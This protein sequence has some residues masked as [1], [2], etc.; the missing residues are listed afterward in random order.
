MRRRSPSVTLRLTVLFALVST[1]GLLSLGFFVGK[2]VSRHFVELDDAVLINKT[3]LV[4][5]FISRVQSADDLE[6]L[7]QQLGDALVE[8]RELAASVVDSSG[9]VVFHTPNAAF[10]A[11]LLHPGE[12]VFDPQAWQ[13]KGIPWRGISSLKPTGNPKIGSLLVA[14]AVDI[15]HHQRFLTS[16]RTSLWLFVAVTAGIS[17]LLGWAAVRR[18]MAPLAKMREDTAIVTA[19]RLDNR[20]DL[21]D[22]PSEFVDLAESLNAMLARLEDS[23]NRL[24]EFSADLAHELRTPISN[25]MTET[26]V[27]LAKTRNS[28]H[29]R[30]ILASNAEEYERLNRMISDMLFIAQ[31]DHGLLVL[32]CE[33]V[34]LVKLARDLFDFFEALASEKR[35]HLSLEGDG[36]ISG[37]RIMIQRALANLMSNA[38]RHSPPGDTVALRLAKSGGRV[39]IDVENV[40]D[41][42]VSTEQLSRVF[43]RFYRVDP[44]RH[45]GGEGAGLGLAITR[46]IVEAH[47]GLI[48]AH[49][50]AN[51]VRFE[52]K[53]PIRQCLDLKELAAS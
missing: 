13:S 30:E 44:S 2:L 11:G 40:S 42:V 6:R 20:I 37:D 14:I 4:S 36:S 15:S 16:F 5:R 45:R 33:E 19:S 51:K 35:V 24:K 27:A 7:P 34:D 52:L 1:A 53:F 12:E 50:E 9:Q 48:S 22:I 25:L 41:S 26:Q 39:E 17:G 43:E 49:A 47:G 18:G 8:H 46:S 31:A 3:H 29:Y 21:D 32:R 28:E 10:P 38:I 23:F